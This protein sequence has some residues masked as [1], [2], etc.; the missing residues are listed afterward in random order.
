MQNPSL[1]QASA[2]YRRLLLAAAMIYVD[3]RLPLSWQILAHDFLSSPTRVLTKA[4]MHTG[5]Y[6]LV[7]SALQLR[8]LSPRAKI[9]LGGVPVLLRRRHPTRDLI[10]CTLAIGLL[11]DV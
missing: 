6:L 8:L 3:A 9:V 11:P 10:A 2:Q 4:H 1:R 5:L 7:N